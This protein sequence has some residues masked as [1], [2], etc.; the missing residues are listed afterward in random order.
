VKVAIVGSGGFIGRHLVNALQ[1][2]GV[3]VLPFS[4]RNGTGLDPQTGQVSND[5]RLNGADAVVYLAQSPHN[6]KAPEM[7]AHMLRVNV[8]SA[9]EVAEQARRDGVG[10]FVYASTGSVYRAAFHPLAEGDPERGDDWYALT[11]LQGER[12]LALFREYMDV[13]VLR[14]FG[15]YGPGQTGRL[16]PGLVRA[17]TTRR[18]VYVERN[19]IDPDDLSGLRLSL[20]YVDDV[21]RAMVRI[22]RDGGPD[23]LNVAGDEAVSV[24][25]ATMAIGEALGIEPVI[26]VADRFRTGDLVADVSRL[27]RYLDAPST[28]FATG[29][30]RTLEQRD[31]D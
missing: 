27:K 19:P 5:L 12:A 17:V 7:A 23:L 29:L 28:P 25:T 4:S 18:P 8:V 1:E 11:K 31:T 20:A 24:W 21:V 15:V 22:G 3:A 9:V 16:I 13:H 30:Q 26:E 2:K 10:R 14:L 6:R